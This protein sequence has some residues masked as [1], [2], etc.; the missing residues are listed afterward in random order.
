[1]RATE[2]LVTQ[3]LAGETKPDKP[4]KTAKAWDPNI[5]AALQDMERALGTRV[6]L[7]GTARK[8]RLIIEYYSPD[9]LMRLYDAILKQP[10]DIS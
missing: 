5:R 10:Q 1:M 8:G 7:S 4:A 6:K 9:D 3:I 2:R